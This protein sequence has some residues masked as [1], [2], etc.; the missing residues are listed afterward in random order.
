VQLHFSALLVVEEFSLGEFQEL[1]QE[2]LLYLVG[3][4]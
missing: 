3:E 1:P 4:A 2:K